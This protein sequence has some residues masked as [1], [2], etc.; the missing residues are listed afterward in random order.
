MKHTNVVFSI[1]LNWLQHFI[2]FSEC[3]RKWINEPPHSKYDCALSKNSDQPLGICQ[4]WRSA[5]TQISP[6][7]FAKSDQYSLCAHWVAKDPS[8]LHANS[9]DS[10][11]TGQMP[12]LIWVFA[13]CTCHFVGF[14]MRRLIHVF[15]LSFQTF[16]S[17]SVILSWWTPPQNRIQNKT[18]WT[19]WHSLI[20]TRS[21]G[22]F[23]S[24]S[25]KI[26]IWKSASRYPS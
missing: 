19:T 26:Q 15:G 16:N 18:N 7:A 25:K 14:V 8:F 9:K 11:Q 22:Q 5:K 3:I 24:R 10:D 1:D 2:R 20:Q 6:W 4:V 13:G 21:R 17:I 12:S 23:Q